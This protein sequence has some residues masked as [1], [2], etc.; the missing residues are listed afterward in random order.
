MSNHCDQRSSESIVRFH[1]AGIDPERIMRTPTKMLL[2]TVLLALGAP[3][4]AAD[5]A[6]DAALANPE[7]TAADRERDARERPAEVLAFAGVKPGMT[8]ADLF[9]GAG[10][11]SEI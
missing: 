4:F 11:Y 10:Y 6:I 1:N 5:A 8:V 9:A 3:S 2:V 7:R